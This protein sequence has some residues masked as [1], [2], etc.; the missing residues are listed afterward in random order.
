MFIQK[1]LGVIICLLLIGTA[2][3]LWITY[4]IQLVKREDDIMEAIR[5]QQRQREER[6][7]QKE[8]KKKKKTEEDDKYLEEARHLIADEKK[9]S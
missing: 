9:E 1:L 4:L 5:E 6:R 3:T 2:A 8:D 7:R